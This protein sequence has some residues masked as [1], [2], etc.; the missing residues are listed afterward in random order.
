MRREIFQAYWLILI[1]QK[2]PTWHCI[3]YHVMGSACILLSKLVTIDTILFL[4]WLYHRGSDLMHFRW[5]FLKY[6]VIFCN[7][8]DSWIRI[9]FHGFGG[10]FLGK[11]P[12]CGNQCIIY[13]LLIVRSWCTQL[14]MSSNLLSGTLLEYSAT[15]CEGRCH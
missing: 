5:G 2:T 3:C 9:M 12:H 7:S 14:N 6:T 15:H 8:L 11:L 13:I 10:I 4:Q 1:S